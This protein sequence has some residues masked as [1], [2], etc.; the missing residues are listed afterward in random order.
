MPV[1]WFIEPLHRTLRASIGFCSTWT[2]VTPGGGGE[3]A[4]Q[5]LRLGHAADDVEGVVAE[6]VRG[7]TEAADQREKDDG[8]GERAA[9]SPGDQPAADRLERMAHE[10]AELYAHPRGQ[11]VLG[12]RCGVG[13]R[14]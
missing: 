10:D 8:R 4:L 2:R 9:Y 5:P 13:R 14:L 7:P 1:G 12:H 3:Q 11:L 6:A